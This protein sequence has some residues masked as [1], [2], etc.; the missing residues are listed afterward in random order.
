MYERLKQKDCKLEVSQTSEGNPV[1]KIFQ[2]EMRMQLRNIGI[3][4]VRGLGS[5]LH[6]AKNKIKYFHCSVL[7]SH[8][9]LFLSIVYYPDRL[10]HLKQSFCFGLL[11]MGDHKL[12]CPAAMYFSTEYPEC[13]YHEEVK[14]SFY[15]F[16]KTVLLA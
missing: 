5:F 15:I 16:V 8:F 2:G 3:T 12:L 14:I 10:L 7:F 4:C 6:K 9:V 13:Q 1:S 11:S